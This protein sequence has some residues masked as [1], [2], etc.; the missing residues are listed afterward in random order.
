M[1][2]PAK[3]SRPQLQQAALALVDREGLAGLTIRALARELGTAPMTL[4]NHVSQREELEVLVVEAVIAHADWP[5]AHFERWQD[6]VHALATAWWQAV[7]A[8]PHAIPLILTR[9]SRSPA[10]MLRAEAL[11]QALARTGRQGEALLQAFRAITALVMGMAQAELAGPL[12]LQ[13]QE[14][15]EDTMARFRTLPVERFPC[16]VEI[17]DAAVKSK[18]ERE[19]EA[20]LGLLLRG[21]D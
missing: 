11:L 9:R 10:V 12:A 21:L 6:A 8:H 17:A 15:A 1:G 2:R 5:E 19:F 4:Y 18:P 20:A 16:L 13:A 14:S 3:I 7:R